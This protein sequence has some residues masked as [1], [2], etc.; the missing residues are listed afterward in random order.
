MK[1]EYLIGFTGYQDGTIEI[2][3]QDRENCDE[4][5]IEKQGT[6]EE[7]ERIGE[8]LPM[9]VFVK[10]GSL[11]EHV[12]DL[13]YRI[14]QLEDALRFYA[15]VK[16]PRKYETSSKSQSGSEITYRKDRFGTLARKTLGMETEPPDFVHT[17]GDGTVYDY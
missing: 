2:I 1:P 16:A 13:E 3:V 5:R 12:K 4:V 9:C 14:I 17:G 15:N 10:G 8:I 7:I 6:M 11:S